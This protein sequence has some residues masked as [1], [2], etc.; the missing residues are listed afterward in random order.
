MSTERR[1]TIYNEGS[2]GS[3]PERPWCVI[4]GLFFP[5]GGRGSRWFATREQAVEAAT[6]FAQR[7]NGLVCISQDEET[8]KIRACCL[9]LY[10][11]PL[12]NG[13][14]KLSDEQLDIFTV[15]S[16]VPTSPECHCIKVPRIEPD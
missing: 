16:G 12:I 8:G 11:K 7:R 9:R 5:R 3:H 14:N 4:R 1:W 6:K 13:L 10:M 2:D 15:S